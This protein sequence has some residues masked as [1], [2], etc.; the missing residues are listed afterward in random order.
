MKY[1]RWLPA[2][3]IIVSALAPVA[4]SAQQCG[5][6]AVVSPAEVLIGESTSEREPGAVHVFEERD[7]EWVEVAVIRGPDPRTRDSFGHALAATG[8]TLFVGAPEDGDGAGG[9]CSV[10]SC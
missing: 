7:G 3:A 10:G 6:S 9:R 5:G 8:P 2:G 1:S 4:L